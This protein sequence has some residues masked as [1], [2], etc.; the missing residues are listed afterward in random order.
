MSLMCEQE[1][2][3]PI[4][5]RGSGSQ[6]GTASLGLPQE[7]A[8]RLEKAA[9]QPGRWRGGWER[10]AGSGEVLYASSFLK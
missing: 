1:G 10:R 9:L 2:K 5:L 6:P 7:L 3:V 4:R 8:E